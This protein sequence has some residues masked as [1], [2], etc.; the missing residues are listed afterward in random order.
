MAEMQKTASDAFLALST[1]IVGRRSVHRWDVTEDTDEGTVTA[2]AWRRDDWRPSHDI[3]E[4]TSYTLSPAAAELAAA[5]MDRGV[6]IESALADECA[7]ETHERGDLCPRGECES[8]DD[9]RRAVAS[10]DER[11]RREDAAEFAAECAR[12]DRM[13]ARS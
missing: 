6:G 13:E 8:C 2:T 3:Q 12:D 1:A 5:A 7:R 4:V 9:H 10:Y 11:Q